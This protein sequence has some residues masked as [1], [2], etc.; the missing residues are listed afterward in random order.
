LY[1]WT[2]SSYTFV[3]DLSGAAGIQGI[4]GAQGTQGIQGLTGSQGITGAQ[5]IQGIQGIT[6]TQGTA[7]AQGTQGIQGIQGIQGRQGITGTGTQGTAGAQGTQG[8][9]GITGGFT[10]NSNAQVNSLGVNTAGSGSA[11]EIRA[12]GNITAYYSDD[13]LKTRIANIPDALSKVTSLNGFYFEANEVA[14]SL[15]YILKKEVGVSAQ[16][17]LAVLPEIIARAP[18]DEKYMTLDY[19]KLV[20]L[21]I[22]AIKELKTEIDLL[23]N[24]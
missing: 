9:Q 6:G 11:G 13:R 20:P 14:Q 12:T 18:I 4:T 22:E 2:G 19:A 1:I 3:D 15:G 23:K 7:G 8:I 24:K 5:G 21:L 17:V 10:T 16:E